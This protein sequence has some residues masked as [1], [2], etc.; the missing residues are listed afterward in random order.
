M[1]DILAAAS[2]SSQS[3]PCVLCVS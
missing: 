2:R 1:K 3:W